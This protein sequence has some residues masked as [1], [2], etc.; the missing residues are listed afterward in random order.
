M[1]KQLKEEMIERLKARAEE[2]GTPEFIDKIAD[3]TITTDP[4]ELVEYLTK[5]DHPAVKLPPMM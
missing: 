2:I 4:A 5:V 3:E 1:P